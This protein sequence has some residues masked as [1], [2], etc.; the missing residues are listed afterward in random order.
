MQNY[1][2]YVNNLVQL[3]CLWLL[4]IVNRFVVVHVVLIVNKMN[5]HRV[6]KYLLQYDK[7]ISCYYIF[8][9]T[10][11]FEKYIFYLHN[12]NDTFYFFLIQVD[13][14]LIPHAPI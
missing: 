5:T 4:L 2:N 13:A 3:F 6:I 9:E 1:Y 7:N 8:I 12:V 14:S 11:E 10:L